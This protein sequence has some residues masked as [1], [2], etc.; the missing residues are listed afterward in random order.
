MS[1]E[2]A[3]KFDR[4]AGK[5]RGGDITYLGTGNDGTRTARNGGRGTDEGVELCMFLTRTRF[6]TVDWIEMP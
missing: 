6:T 4:G 3:F 2:K 5:V 1:V